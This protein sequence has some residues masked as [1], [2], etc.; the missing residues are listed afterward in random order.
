[1][2]NVSLIVV[3]Y[4][5]CLTV[6]MHEPVPKSHLKYH[7]FI[8]EKPVSFGD[9]Q[10]ERITSPQESDRWKLTFSYRDFASMCAD[11]RTIHYE[12]AL[13]SRSCKPTSLGVVPCKVPAK[14][15]A[16][17][18]TWC[19]P[20]FVASQGRVGVGSRVKSH[21]FLCAFMGCSSETGM[22]FGRNNTTEK[23]GR[24]R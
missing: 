14:P 15:S 20:W 18:A 9:L 17:Q 21:W 8:I 19:V 3:I 5:V 10:R 11:F 1:M 6:G 4:S 22:K 13:F 23:S 2:K 16:P 12:S 7:S 24:I